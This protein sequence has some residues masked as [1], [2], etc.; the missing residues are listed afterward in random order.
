MGVLLGTMFFGM[1][2]VSMQMNILPASDETVLSQL[3]RVVFGDSSVLY[4]VLQISTA[5]ILVLA[6]NTSFADFPRLASILARDRFLPRLFQFRGDRLAFTSGIVALALLAIVLVVVFNGSVDQLIPLYAVGVF[7]SFT[8]SQAGHGA[9][10][11]AKCARRAGSD[12]PRSMASARSRR[13]IVTLVIAFSKFAEGAW[14][15]VLLIPILIGI[16]YAI[17]VHYKRI[18]GARRAETPLLPEEVVIRAVVPIA[19]LGIPARQA[20]AFARAVAG[21]DPTS[22]PST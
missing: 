8:L 1:T 4:I 19:D 21:D 22:S 9:S 7:A 5:L 2:F 13:G 14:L 6:A 11:G 10:T 12:R 17:H 15:V 3:G 16:F 18:E 20:L